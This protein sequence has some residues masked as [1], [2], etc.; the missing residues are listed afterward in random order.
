MTTTR[1]IVRGEDSPVGGYDTRELR[2]ERRSVVERQV[3]S[4]LSLHVKEQNVNRVSI[5]QR[6]ERRYDKGKKL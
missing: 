2:S 3:S 4:S 6:Q 1:E 5:L